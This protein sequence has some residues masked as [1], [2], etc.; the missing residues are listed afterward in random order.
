MISTKIRG[1]W[2]LRVIG[3]LVTSI[4]VLCLV[5]ILWIIVAAIIWKVS[6]RSNRQHPA[7][8]RRE[9]GSNGFA[10]AAFGSPTATAFDSAAAATADESDSY[11]ASLTFADS[12]P[13][14]NPATGLPMM[15]DWVD[16]MGNPY[17][18]DLTS[19]HDHF[20]SPAGIDENWTSHNS[21]HDWNSSSD[22][23]W[24]S[25]SSD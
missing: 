21:D 10:A 4:F 18:F 15:D 19:I 17:G 20:H 3:T 25:S 13:L 12:R 16:V 23:S 8:R 2:I 6:S 1:K 11:S 5:P 24:S 14:V 22:D 9:R 7:A